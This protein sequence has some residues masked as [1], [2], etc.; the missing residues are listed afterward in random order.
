[1]GE[2]HG[3][4]RIGGV[5]TKDA[6]ETLDEGVLRRLSRLA[7]SIDDLLLLASG[8]ERCTRKHRLAVLQQFGR[9]RN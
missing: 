5:V 6:D 3:Q 1:M 2:A 4:V 8:D 9:L 7:V